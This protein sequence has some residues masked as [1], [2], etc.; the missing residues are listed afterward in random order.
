MTL[1]SAL[2][3]GLLQHR[4]HQ[5]RVHQFRYRCSLL[6]LDLDEQQQVFGL[7]QLWS[8]RWWSPMRFR[9]T[10]YLRA[11]RQ[12]EESLKACAQRLVSEQLQLE[13]DGAVQLLT[14]IRS[15]GML[16]NPASFFYCYDRHGALRGIICEVTNTP[17][18]EHFCY[19]L[20]ANP[21]EQ[22]QNFTL[23]KRFHVSPFLPLQA[24]YHMRFSRP[25]ERVQVHIA[26]QQGDQRLFSASLSLQRKQL[27]ARLLRREALSFPFMVL[28]TLTGIYWQALRLLIKRIPLFDHSPARQ[29]VAAHPLRPVKE[30][31]DETEQT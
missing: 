13:I 30:S 25:G 2:Y 8:G 20:E 12:P 23:H 26:H 14:Q 31:R 9:E 5:P 1:N 19:V 11:E 10:D 22:Q 3:S 7:S 24:D 29:S 21:N 16:F 17:W 4:R 27:S 6:L 28:R 15:F 18:G